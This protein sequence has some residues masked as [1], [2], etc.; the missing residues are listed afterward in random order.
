MR[1]VPFIGMV[2]GFLLLPVVSWWLGEPLE[3]TLVYSALF[4]LMMARRVTAGLRSDLKESHDIRRVLL[5]RLLY[6]RAT[7]E[8]RQGTS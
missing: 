2:A 3:V 7:G 1:K 6:D 8:W 5:K 4:V